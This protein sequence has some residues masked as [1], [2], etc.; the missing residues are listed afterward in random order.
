[1]ANSKTK[2]GWLSKVLENV[3][4]TPEYLKSKMYSRYDRDTSDML[5]RHNLGE[6]VVGAR[7]YDTIYK[8]VKNKLKSGDQIGAYSYVKE[9][10][11]KVKSQKY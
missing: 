11:K 9:Q 2:N 4:A 6:T 1:M 10:L 8:T 7:N 3:K 5:K